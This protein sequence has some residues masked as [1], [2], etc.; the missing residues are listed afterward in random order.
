MADDREMQAALLNMM[1][2]YGSENVARAVANARLAQQQQAYGAQ[3]GE[4]AGAS[5][6]A[7]G[8]AG[9]GMS[10]GNQQYN[11]QSQSMS[12]SYK[13][14]MGGLPQPFPGVPQDYGTIPNAAAPLPQA[15]SGL[16][17][18]MGPA[19]MDGPSQNTQQKLAQVLGNDPDLAA[20]YSKLLASNPQMEAQVLQML[21]QSGMGQQT[22]MQQSM[23]LGGAQAA[24]Q[25][26]QAGIMPS[27]IGQMASA[28]FDQTI[29]AM[30]AQ[31][32]R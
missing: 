5:P 22:P 9:G 13:G 14:P 16:I 20:L 23:A 32:R 4:G 11:A 19:P 24:G 1:Q 8:A 26:Q 7:A 6:M 3:P 31:G 18:G 17:P 30:Q 25:L 10:A 2:Q 27:P 12:M 28:P 15:P 29:A 21:G